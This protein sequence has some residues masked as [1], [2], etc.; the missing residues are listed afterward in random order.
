MVR[1]NALRVIAHGRL[2]LVAAGRRQHIG[3]RAGADTRLPIALAVRAQ[4][5]RGRRGAAVESFEL[6]RF[7][8]QRATSALKACRHELC[9]T[10]LTASLL[11]LLQDP[12]RHLGDAY[13][14]LQDVQGVKVSKCQGSISCC[15]ANKDPSRIAFAYGHERKQEHRRTGTEAGKRGAWRVACTD[16]NWGS[17]Y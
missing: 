17:C 14:H 10:G 5:T 8:A 16:D 15:G 1:E 7:R 13:F 9:I 3:L 4:A 11:L 12:R 2:A 6:S